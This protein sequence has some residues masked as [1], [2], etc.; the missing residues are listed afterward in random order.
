MPKKG[1][2][3]K[4]TSGPGARK[5]PPQQKKVSKPTSGPGARKSPPT[6]AKGPPTIYKTGNNSKPP[7]SLVLEN[8]QGQTA[9][10]EQIGKVNQ[11][12]PGTQRASRANA[13]QAAGAPKILKPQPKK[14][15]KPKGS[16]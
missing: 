14:S 15:N 16:K 12:G 1:A 8:N 4:P 10:Y 6:K 2:A 9:V 11:P 3:P 5:S 7:P 13:A